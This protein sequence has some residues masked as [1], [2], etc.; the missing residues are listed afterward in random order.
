MEPAVGT[1][2]QIR[3]PLRSF[4]SVTQGTFVVKEAGDASAPPVIRGRRG[5]ED[6]DAVEQLC[7]FIKGGQRR[8]SVNGISAET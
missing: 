8:N 2:V 6:E 4:S 3:H 1:M 5:K 7:Y